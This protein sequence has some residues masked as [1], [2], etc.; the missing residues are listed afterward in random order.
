MSALTRVQAE[1]LAFIRAFIK[2]HGISPTFE[3]IAAGVGLKSKGWAHGIVVALAERGALT[4]LPHRGRSI[5]IIPP[6]R[7]PEGID[8]LPNQLAVWVRV[9]AA[10]AGVTPL[11][12]VTEAVRDAYTMRKIREQ[13]VSRETSGGT[14]AA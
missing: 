8:F 14:K 11:D 5:E 4:F 7:A 3:E 9:V 2:E 10:K 13:V 1:A 12:V 6:P